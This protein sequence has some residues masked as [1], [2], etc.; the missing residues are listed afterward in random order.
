MAFLCRGCSRRYGNKIYSIGDSG[1]INID[2]KRIKLDKPLCSLDKLW[3]ACAESDYK[4]NIYID[5]LNTNRIVDRQCRKIT[6]QDLAFQEEKPVEGSNY[7]AY[8]Y[9]IENINP[10]GGGYFHNVL[11]SHFYNILDGKDITQPSFS[12]YTM[13]NTN[14]AIL[15][16][17]VEDKEKLEDETICFI[18]PEVKKEEN[19]NE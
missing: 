7:K 2:D 8:I 12:Y 4:F 1:Y 5:K 18:I 17:Y 16:I 14:S 19:K 9:K 15:T 10:D 3:D 13:L 11:S 6:M